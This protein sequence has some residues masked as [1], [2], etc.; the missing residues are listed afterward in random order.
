MRHYRV[1][2]DASVLRWLTAEVIAYRITR[3]R[4]PAMALEIKGLRAKALKAASHLDRLNAAYDAFNE[5]APAHAADVEGLTPQITALGEDL[6]FATQVLGNSVNGSGDGAKVEQQQT[7][8]P[9]LK[10]NDDSPPEVGEASTFRA[11][12]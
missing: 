9:D 5:A 3:P 8:V 4:R 2:A 1:I 12:E 6:A 11:A 10:L 7:K